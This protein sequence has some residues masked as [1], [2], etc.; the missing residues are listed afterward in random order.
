M[1]F[2][3]LG[4]IAEVLGGILFVDVALVAVAMVRGGMASLMTVHAGER[5]RIVVERCAELGFDAIG[6][7]ELF[8]GMKT[9]LEELEAVLVDREQI[10]VR[11][12]LEIP[13]ERLDV[14]LI[15]DGDELVDGIVEVVY[16]RFAVRGKHGEAVFRMG[17]YI[18]VAIRLEQVELCKDALVVL[19][20]VV[21]LEQV[22]RFG[23]K[24]LVPY[25]VLTVFRCMAVGCHIQRYERPL[26]VRKQGRVEFALYGYV[27][28]I[29]SH[30]CSLRVL[31]CRF[32]TRNR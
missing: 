30:G 10:V 3:R 12:E 1:V 20:V 2:D 17:P 23:Y 4:R 28:Q 8:Y 16:R 27:R 9:S 7:F 31:A 32:G 11:A 14:E 15:G 5:V 6:H 22:L 29:G 13:D 26:V 18:G 24:V 25:G 21:E 19:A